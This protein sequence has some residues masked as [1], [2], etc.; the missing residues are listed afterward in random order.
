M[1]AICSC[2]TRFDKSDVKHFP[3]V[4]L[5]YLGEGW[6]PLTSKQ[7]TLH[8]GELEVFFLHA[9]LIFCSV[10]SQLRGTM[11]NRLIREYFPILLFWLGHFVK[12]QKVFSTWY[13]A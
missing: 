2:S 5:A 10:A 8:I 7:I 13:M 1:R 9:S 6:S 12:S 3:I 11:V 4:Y